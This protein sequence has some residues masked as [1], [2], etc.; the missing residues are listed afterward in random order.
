VAAE[1][2]R[3]RENEAVRRRIK[4][5]KAITD[6]RI[7]EEAVGAASGGLAAGVGKP[8]SHARGQGARRRT[9]ARPRR[10]AARGAELALNARGLLFVRGGK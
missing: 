3:Q 9:P 4:S 6:D 10:E 8:P 7:A 2:E 5:T 1:E